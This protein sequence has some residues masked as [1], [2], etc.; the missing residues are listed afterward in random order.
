[1]VNRLI[2]PDDTTTFVPLLTYISGDLEVASPRFTQRGDFD[3]LTDLSPSLNTG[4]KTIAAKKLEQA[5]VTQKAADD[6]I[7]QRLSDETRRV[8]LVNPQGP[9]LSVAKTSSEFAADVM[10]IT[11]LADKALEQ[12]VEYLE[13]KYPQ[14]SVPG[15][16]ALSPRPHTILAVSTDSPSKG[17]RKPQK[18]TIESAHPQMLITDGT[19][20]DP[21]FTTNN[22]GCNISKYMQTVSNTTNEFLKTRTIVLH[23]TDTLAVYLEPLNLSPW[24]F[25]T[26]S[27]ENMGPLNTLNSVFL[28]S[29]A[30]VALITRGGA[31]FDGLFLVN[32]YNYGVKDYNSGSLDNQ[33]LF[34][35]W[36]SNL[37]Y[38]PYRFR[39]TDLGKRIWNVLGSVPNYHGF[40]P[41]YP[42]LTKIIRSF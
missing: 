9:V 42:S 3:Q 39:G 27:K 4:A 12:T 6:K 40:Y 35:P 29:R 13:N 10:H 31:E 38:A 34:I 26:G 22:A 19:I 30:D 7:E 20:L 23:D 1:V 36:D 41:W 37:L 21:G 2:H 15:S 32:Q 28:G 11:Q 24:D 18:I 8:V 33:K 16:V 14:L 25:T 5:Q 17:V